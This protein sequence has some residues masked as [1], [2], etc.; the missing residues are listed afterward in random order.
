VL[1]LPEDAHMSYISHHREKEEQTQSCQKTEQTNGNIE[2]TRS[3][4]G[5]TTLTGLS[6]T[7]SESN[8]EILSAETP[9]SMGMDNTAQDIRSSHGLNP[10]ASSAKGSK[11]SKD[12]LRVSSCAVVIA[13][14]WQHF[15][16]Y[17]LVATL[18]P[19]TSSSS[20]Q[21][22][23]VPVDYSA[24][25]LW[26]LDL[27]A[28]L[29][30]RPVIDL[31]Y[32]IRETVLIP[33]SRD[34]TYTKSLSPDMARSDASEGGGK[35]KSSGASITDVSLV[36]L[37]GLGNL[38]RFDVCPFVE[39]D[40]D[41]VVESNDKHKRKE[42]RI[43]VF[44][45]CI[46]EGFTNLERVDGSP[47]LPAPLKYAL[48][49][50]PDGDEEAASL[51][52]GTEF[53]CK[54][55]LPLMHDMG[56][57]AGP[58]LH[59]ISP[60][61]LT[62]FGCIAGTLALHLRTHSLSL[63]HDMNVSPGSRLLRTGGTAT[64]AVSSVLIHYLD[65]LVEAV[66]GVKLD[67][68]RRDVMKIERDANTAA[69]TVNK[70]RLISDLLQS[71]RREPH[72]MELIVRALESRWR[73]VAEASREACTTSNYALTSSVL[74]SCDDQVL[75][76]V[77]SR[78]GR[79]LEPYASQNLFPLPSV[80]RLPSA[81]KSI[82]LGGNSSLAVSDDSSVQFPMFRCSDSP[83]NPLALLEL[84]L[85]NNRLHHA[86]R[87]LMLACEQNGGSTSVVTI[88]SSLVI[89]IELLTSCLKELSLLIAGECLD[90]CLRLEL[91]IRTFE[92]SNSRD[93]GRGSASSGS[94]EASGN[95]RTQDKR[96]FD[97]DNDGH[98]QNWGGGLFSTLGRG[99][100]GF[101]SILDDE[102]PFTL[103]GTEPG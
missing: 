6:S 3:Q 46:G 56:L 57:L 40:T 89:A 99:V 12:E 87:L 91:M 16:C 39:K 52:N 102:R 36:V 1:L 31:S 38:L 32:P 23:L 24:T 41:V 44:V 10:K 82:S 74:F 55:Y 43:E 19:V 14:G 8:E 81:A 48:M 30:P 27:K 2:T 35:V 101:L 9:R 94:K 96:S 45:E 86:S 47:T 34:D 59:K 67:G 90:F 79:K 42:S 93:F 21:T 54:I 26:V 4:S 62:P 37:D 64:V 33:S 68:D 65:G 100:L 49:L 15:H 83:W 88:A 95:N 71:V 103:N 7:V 69:V 53:C 92:E 77:I 80:D 51:E 60:T 76:E 66:T 22:Y 70:T 97:D 18:E 20:S 25:V 98:S 78:L 84:C 11:S 17:K 13:D 50:Y 73:A 63:P 28:V 5:E 58:A 72:E 29:G 75:L 61:S 85:T